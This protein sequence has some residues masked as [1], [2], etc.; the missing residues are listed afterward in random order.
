MTESPQILIVEDEIIV[1]EDLKEILEGMGYRVTGIAGT[2]TEA[3]DLAGRLRPDLILMDIVL[4]SSE[5]DGIEAAER[6]RR[7]SDIPVIYVTAFADDATLDRAKATG[8]TGYIIKPYNERDLRTAIELALSRNAVEKER[9]ERKQAVSAL[10][11]TT[12]DPQ[13]LLDGEYTVRALNDA[14]AER[15]GGAESDL[16]GSSILQCIESGGVSKT[17]L[18]MVDAGRSGRPVR[19]EE[20]IGGRWYDTTVSPATD[21]FGNVAT[22]AV[23]SHDVTA[24]KQAERELESLNKELQKEQRN[25]RV[26]ASALGEMDDI[27]IITDASGRI[28]YGNGASEKRLGYTPGDLGGRHISELA[29]PENLFPLRVDV[30]MDGV[31][32]TWRGTLIIRNR[33]GVTIRTNMKSTPV[34]N[35]DRVTHRVFVL[36]EI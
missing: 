24:M 6:I 13:I 15:L 26:L 22:I 8:P 5:I 31:E 17:F 10:L 33:Y 23:L 7:K 21:S 34:S 2:G 11:N 29:D 14:M 36:R 25:L 9:N 1:A 28:T 3:V 18:E 35:G 4:D 27:V 30:F 12:S 19:F 16:I 32:K 20:E